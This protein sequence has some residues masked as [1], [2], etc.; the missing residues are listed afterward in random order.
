M[1]V[2]TACRH[3]LLIMTLMHG[4]AVVS[5][6]T[7]GVD[8]LRCATS[9]IAASQWS[10][11]ERDY[12]CA[13]AEA[14]IAFLR[15]AGLDYGGGLTIRPLDSAPMEYRGCELGHFDTGRN[16]IQLLPL[17][18]AVG[19]QRLTSAFDVPMTPALWASY[20]S[21]EV[22][23]AVIERHFAKGA[24]RF[25]ASE[26]IAAVVQM[27]T[28]EPALR[29]TI[30]ANFSDLDAYPSVDAISSLYYLMAPGQFAV[31]V[32]RHYLNLG[33]A[34][35]EFMRWLLRNGLPR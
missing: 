1:K 17:A 10:A 16:E 23:H 3:L 12:V 2:A 15:D 25:T 13:A 26:Y 35:P 30:L 34:G 27:Q 21:H 32:Y 31:K 14:A 28:M 11:A 7:G 9:G 22:A 20:I 29:E 33:D 4:G 18:P 5:G 19:A 6:D 24:R 8:E